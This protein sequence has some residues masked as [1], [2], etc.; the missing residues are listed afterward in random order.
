MTNLELVLK[1][2]RQSSE[3]AANQPTFYDA[4][5][6]V[7]AKA[8]QRKALAGAGTA[9]LAGLGTG[10][11]LR[12][13]L[14]LLEMSRQGA[15]PPQA[16]APTGQIEVPVDDEK[17]AA[18]AD[19]LKGDYAKSTSGVPWAI[20]AA[21]GAGAAGAYGGWKGIDALLEQR[22]KGELEAELEKAK[23]DYEAALSGDTKLAE[24]LDEL[25]DHVEKQ[26]VSA[27]DAAG[28]ATG[29]YGV[30]GGTSALLAAIMAYQYGKKRQR[31]SLLEA[32]QEKR[33]RQRFARQPVPIQVRPVPKQHE[34]DP[35]QASKSPFQAAP[36]LDEREDQLDK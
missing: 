27:S 35:L 28:T 8:L 2:S 13:I 18:L 12:G 1:A 19:F 23:M 10:A 7:T 6:H 3:K 17:I 14:G 36:S 20:P 22:R 31:R 33:R 29:L 26:A 11:G 30:Y 5:Q 16:Q 4:V 32:A 24:D 15:Q 25:Y 9:A 34:Q 21:V